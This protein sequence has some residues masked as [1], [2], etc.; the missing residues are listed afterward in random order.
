MAKE[1]E[2]KYLAVEESI[3]KGLESKYFLQGYIHIDKQKQVRVRVNITDHKA[4]MC[5]KYMGLA[6][7]NEFETEMNVPEALE[8]YYLCPFR[9]RKK[10]QSMKGPAGLHFDFDY[11]ENGD[12]IVEVELPHMKFDFDK[13]SYPFIGE[14]VNNQYKYSNYSYAGLPEELYK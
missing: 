2:I 14:D 7:R 9:V 13:R 3:P 10:R 5:I 11:Y 8:L 6:M 4:Y 12:V 1:I